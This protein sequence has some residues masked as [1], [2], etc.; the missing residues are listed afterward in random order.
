MRLDLQSI[1]TQYLA[2]ATI[3]WMHP[4]DTSL[5]LSDNKLGHIKTSAEIIELIQA[6][7][8]HVTSLDLGDNLLYKLSVSDLITLAQAFPANLTSLSLSGNFLNRKPTEEV[9]A[10]IKNLP[11]SIKSLDLGRHFF[12]TIYPKNCG[13]KIDKD[14]EILIEVIKALNPNLESLSLACCNLGWR[15]PEKVIELFKSLPPNLNSLSLRN[16]DLDQ[17]SATDLITVIKALPPL[18]SLNLSSNRLDKLSSSQFVSITDVPTPN[19]RYSESRITDSSL[20]LF[21]PKR[22]ETSGAPTT[23]TINQYQ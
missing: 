3:R 7:P 14:G 8:Y 10:F 6:I 9:I 19:E 15:S 22:T 18:K 12:D 23:Q 20:G 17:F 21:T 5:D 11:A 1:D 13:P 2:T 16:N 4:D